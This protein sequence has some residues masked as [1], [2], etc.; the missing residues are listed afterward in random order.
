M[1]ADNK[2]INKREEEIKNAKILSW[3]TLPQGLRP[4]FCK[5]ANI[6]HKISLQPLL[7]ASYKLLPAVNPHLTEPLS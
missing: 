7:P 4:V 5:L 1:Q 2:K 3:F 6:D